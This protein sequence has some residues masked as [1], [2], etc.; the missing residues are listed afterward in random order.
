ML[1]WL[2]MLTFQTSILQKTTQLS[3][4][5]ASNNSKTEMSH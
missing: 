1:T 4:D 2:E 5:Q 3:I